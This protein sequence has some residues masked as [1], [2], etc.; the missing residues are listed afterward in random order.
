MRLSAVAESGSLWSR[1][2]VED[3]CRETCK[4][5]GGSVGVGE[6]KSV[7]SPCLGSV[8][9]RPS[10]THVAALSGGDS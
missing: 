7:C 3:E 4:G 8:T 10:D 9:V 6:E 5:R 2:T 1:L